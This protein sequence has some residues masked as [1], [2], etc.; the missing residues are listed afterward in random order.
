M[1]QIGQ[2][3]LVMLAAKLEELEG[4]CARLA[5]ENADLRDRVRALMG[6]AGATNGPNAIAPNTKR[7]RYQRARYQRAK[8]QANGTLQAGGRRVGTNS[9][10]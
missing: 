7:A 10:G 8:Y 4:V 6:G 9:P 3:Q 2:K 1:A 5:L